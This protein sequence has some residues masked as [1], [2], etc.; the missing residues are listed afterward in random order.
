MNEVNVIYEN[1]EIKKINKNIDIIRLKSY[2]R[3]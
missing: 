1:N 2:G 3:E